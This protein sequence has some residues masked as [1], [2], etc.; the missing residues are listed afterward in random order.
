MTELAYL[1]RLP[2]TLMILLASLSASGA[3]SPDSVSAYSVTIR[4]DNVSIVSVI[5][6]EGITST[7]FEGFGKMRQ[8]LRGAIVL[9]DGRVFGLDYRTGSFTTTTLDEAIANQQAERELILRGLTRLDLR[10]TAPYFSPPSL[11]SFGGRTKIHGVPA[12]GYVLKDGNRTWHLYYAIG[13]PRPPIH[14][15]SKLAHLYSVV[16]NGANHHCARDADDENP[17]S[18]GD[19]SVASAHHVAGRVLLRVELEAGRGWHTIFN[20][21]EV[22]QERVPSAIF[23]PPIGWHLQP[24][25]VRNRGPLSTALRAPELMT[26]PLF[27]MRASLSAE[28]SADVYTVRL[29]PITLRKAQPPSMLASPPPADTSAHVVWGPG[30]VIEYPEVYLYF[31]GAKF[32]NPAHTVAVYEIAS[33]FQRDFDAR[34]S[35]FLTQYGV[36]AGHVIRLRFDSSNPPGY[37][38]DGGVGA[39]LGAFVL[40]EGLNG[41][42]PLFWWTVGG[43]DPLYAVFV[44]EADV[45]SASWDGVHLLAPNLVNAVVPFPFNLFVHQGMPYMLVKVPDRALNLGFEALL[46]RD[47]CHGASPPALC[48]D[49]P[50]FDEATRRAS[51]EYVEAVTDPLPFFGWSDPFEA[52]RG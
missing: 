42:S 4:Q 50:W 13:L 31:W 27:G 32:Q 34:Y 45:N 19:D 17:D 24:K 29:L 40:K 6:G 52:A 46:Y 51:H 9:N 25:G 37:A 11:Q 47:T 21:E 5:S 10:L 48:A 36:T 15:R 30:P 49:I 44:P 28:T 1:A 35:G 3:E 16:P 18:Y 39:A 22:H 23:A 14:L 43:H 7:Q 33:S 41:D 12:Q 38:G 8:P 20:V 2:V 26:Q